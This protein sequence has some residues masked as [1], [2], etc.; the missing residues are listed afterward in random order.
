MSTRD[1][2]RKGGLD[3]AVISSFFLEV[4][5][6]QDNRSQLY[7]TLYKMTLYSLDPID[8]ILEATKVLV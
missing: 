3:E 5:E 4:V 1:E 7:G 2:C 8:C 6:G